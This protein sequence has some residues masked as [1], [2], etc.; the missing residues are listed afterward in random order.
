MRSS[1]A[2]R[3]LE[4]ASSQDFLCRQP[5]LRSSHILSDCSLVLYPPE[6][7]LPGSLA[8]SQIVAIYPLDSAPDVLLICEG[9]TGV[10]ISFFIHLHSPSSPI[11][12]LFRRIV[13]RCILLNPSTIFPCRPSCHGWVSRVTTGCAGEV[14]QSWRTE[15][16]FMVDIRDVGYGSKRRTTNLSLVLNPDCRNFRSRACFASSLSRDLVMQP[17]L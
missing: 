5:P 13:G 11:R 12:A 3:R 9:A 4:S 15:L 17:S 16:W 2:Y 14:D 7:R 8:V 1:L 6:Y 10:I